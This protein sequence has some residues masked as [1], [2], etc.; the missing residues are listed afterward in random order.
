MLGSTH[1]Y[2]GPSVRERWLSCGGSLCQPL[3][4]CWPRL[5]A[6]YGV[7]E[8]SQRELKLAMPQLMC[9]KL[10]ESGAQGVGVE[11]DGSSHT[12]HACYI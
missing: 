11:V 12:A 2:N 3:S 8:S 7:E 10:V 5:S 9:A 6:E 1:T 4:L